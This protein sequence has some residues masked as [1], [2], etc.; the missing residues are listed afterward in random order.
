MLT[1]N[2]ISPPTKEEIRMDQ[3]PTLSKWSFIPLYK[4][5]ANGGLLHWQIGF[6]G[7][8]KLELNHGDETHENNELIDLKI[9]EKI[10][11]P[12]DYALREARRLYGLKYQEGYQPPGSM[13]PPF[14]KVM[15]PLD[16]KPSSIKTWPVY[17]QPKLHGLKMLCQNMGMGHIA[18]RTGSNNPYCNL[19]HLERDLKRFFEY[20]PR[21]SVLDGDLYS[22]KI[23]YPTLVSAVKT[24]TSEH[25]QLKEIQYWI[26]DIYY[27]DSEGSPFEKRYALLVNAFRHYIQDLSPNNKSDDITVVPTTFIV[28][29]AQIAQNH[30]QVLRINQQYQ[31]AGYQGVLVKKISNGFIPGSKQYDESLYKQ[32][33]GV[34]I[35]KYK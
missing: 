3:S 17:T 19:N 7:I 14:I 2:I 21:Y 11:S 13:S 4:L 20:L 18:M 1:L 6:D 10:F 8:N 28:V 23:E 15:K 22:P 32:G 27:E 9:E 30:E 25:P 16:Y 31:A 5:S 33:P 34:H 29:S 26:S 24:I 12:R 35:L